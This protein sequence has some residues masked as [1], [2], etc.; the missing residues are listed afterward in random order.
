M[1]PAAMERVR[2]IGGLIIRA[3]DPL[4]LGRRDSEPLGINLTPSNSEGQPWA[5]EGGPTIF[6]SCASA[7]V[8]QVVRTRTW[9]IDFRLTVLDGMAT[10]LRAAGIAVELDPEEHPNGRSARFRDPEGNPVERWEPK[11]P[12]DGRRPPQRRR[13]AAR[14]K[15]G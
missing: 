4:A 11:S 3:R 14:S 6:T 1:V 15:N 8:F 9:T 13:S 7:A 5:S 12:E 2:G 10:W